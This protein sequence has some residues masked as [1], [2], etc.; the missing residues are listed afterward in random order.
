M[1]TGTLWALEE[2]FHNNDTQTIVNLF[3]NVQR[4]IFTTDYVCRIEEYESDWIRL[5]RYRQPGVVPRRSARLAQKQQKSETIAKARYNYLTSHICCT[6]S[7]KQ[8]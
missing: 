5:A 8:F 1:S 4:Q 2:F 7:N 3:P 6:T